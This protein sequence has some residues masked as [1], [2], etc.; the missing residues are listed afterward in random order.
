MQKKLISLFIILFYILNIWLFKLFIFFIADIIS[1]TKTLSG[2]NLST[3]LF[4]LKNIL[5]FKT[6]IFYEQN[7]LNCSDLSEIFKNIFNVIVTNLMLECN[8]LGAEVNFMFLL[9]VIK[10]KLIKLEF[11]EYIFY[12]YC[13]R[14]VYMIHVEDYDL[15]TK[16]EYIIFFLISMLLYILTK[17]R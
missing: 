6:M 3:L 14:F 8:L 7:I 10:Y 2:N 5:N 12:I 17:S 16:I 11:D 1:L 15:H 13:Y 9:N 4:N